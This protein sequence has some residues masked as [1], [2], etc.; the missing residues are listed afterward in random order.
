M[1]NNKIKLTL[2]PNHN[3]PQF[4][5]LNKKI[6][7]SNSY[8]NNKITL[9]NKNINKMNNKTKLSHN[10]IIRQKNKI[11]IRPSKERVKT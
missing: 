6:Y 10:K 4:H 5:N 2:N 3:K 1:H 11:N 7:I 9:H 8:I